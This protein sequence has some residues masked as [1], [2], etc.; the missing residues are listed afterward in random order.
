VNRAERID[1]RS[2]RRI[3]LADLYDRFAAGLFRFLC[4][5]IGER[6]SARDLVQEVFVNL[7]PLLDEPD[8]E[9]PPT[10]VYAIA[11][12]LAITRLRRIK[13]E[14][15]WI[16]ADEDGI[17]LGRAAAKGDDPQRELERAELRRSLTMALSALPEGQRE[18]FLLSELEGFS[19]EDIGTI[20]DLPPGTVASR[21]H[22]AA[23]KLRQ[24]MEKKGHA[25]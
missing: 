10:Y 7:H 12:N 3:R 24:S 19:Y 8:F 9:P 25:L 6:E 22:L 13:L 4:A 17:A 1:G 2:E 14:R 5:M 23:Q 15:R 18:V 21:K 20:L 11:R 16:D